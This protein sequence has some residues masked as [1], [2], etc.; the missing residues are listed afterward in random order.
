[1]VMEDPTALPPVSDVLTHAVRQL[2]HAGIDD[3]RRNAE[4]M[5]CAL[6]KV[7]RAGLYAFPERPVPPAVRH[8]LAAMLERRMRREPL[9]YIL[10]FT[11][12]F[13][14]RLRVTPDVLI[15]RPETEHLV[16]RA[17]AEVAGRAAPRILDVGT[18]SGCIP[19]ALMTH[20]P[21]ARITAVDISEAALAVAAENAREAGAAIR[22]ARFDAL[23]DPLIALAEAPFDLIV[24]NPPYVPLADLAG[25]AP[26]VSGHEPHAAL[27]AGDDALAFYRVLA[28]GG[29]DALRP[30]G[31]IL[32]EV[33]AAY[34]A[35]VAALFQ[36]A[37]FADATVH[38]DLSGR[39]RIVAARQRPA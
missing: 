12:F 31:A 7:G 20:R 23:S 26:E 34:A 18:G 39:P 11:E 16:E 21:D 2:E 10:G 4:W 15:P 30:E 22:F 29:P 28:A 37:G 3:A 9:Q 25:L 27:F 8:D 35:S 24:S 38:P 1:M 36:A 19:I 5:L 33:Y 32:V 14:V 17:L 6:L 13:G